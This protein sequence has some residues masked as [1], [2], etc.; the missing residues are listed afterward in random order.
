[1]IRERVSTQGVIRPLEQAEDLPAFA[2]PP[3][4]IGVVS[5]LAMKRYLDGRCKF[6]KKFKKTM[7]TIEKVRRRNLDLAHQDAVR[8]MTQLQTYLEQDDR[9]RG[10]DRKETATDKNARHDASSSRKSRA[11]RGRSSSRSKTRSK[12]S[13]RSRSKTR[14]TAKGIREALSTSGSW[15]WAWALDVDERPPPSSIVSRRDTDEAVRLARIADQCVLMEENMM[16]GN[17]LWSMIVNFLTVSPDKSSHSLRH[18]HHHEKKQHEKDG[19]EDEQGK[20][21]SKRE[22]IRSRF[23]QFVAEQRKFHFFGRDSDTAVPAQA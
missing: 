2:L 9:S 3:E 22:R 11:S 5:E 10:D 4:L 14:D 15:S 13:G 7:K 6:D 8:H 1:M 18:G 17:N 21:T 20:S 12:S 23:A 16:S 19:R